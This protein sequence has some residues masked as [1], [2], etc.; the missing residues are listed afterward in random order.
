[1]NNLNP[2]NVTLLVILAGIFF[3]VIGLGLFLVMAFLKFKEQ[4]AQLQNQVTEKVYEQFF[5]LTTKLNTDLK[6][7]R[8]ELQLGLSRSTQQL[9]QKL[10]NMSSEV[11]AKLEKNITQGFTYFEKVQ[12]S[13][14]QAEKQLSQLNLVGDSVQ[15]LKQ[16]LSLPHLRGKLLGEA[17]LE[18]VLA[19]F[20]PAGYFALQYQI[21][22]NLVDAVVI[23]KHLNLVLPIDSK[24]SMEQI[25]PLFDQASSP[26]NLKIARKKL[27][28]VTRTNA[29]DIRAKYIKTKLGTTDFALMYL[30]SETLYFEVI[31]DT[32]LWS[33]ITE[34]KIYPVSP[35]TLAIT[36][37][38]I[39]KSVQYYEMA[40]DVQKTLAQLATARDHLEKFKTRFDDI[41]EKLFKAQD[42]FNKASTHYERYTSS[43]QKLDIK[44]EA[45]PPS[46]AI[47]FS[48]PPEV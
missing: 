13:L 48:A 14:V 24:F 40:K 34:Q 7:N 36:V 32:E 30:P 35:N 21:D 26:E 42:S 25:A 17:S 43:L 19:D 3:T 8:E 15:E 29:K 38:T 31:R 41:G 39:S 37:N 6:N 11:G 27:S 23:F 12:N 16:V 4:N 1:M 28:E 45:V 2:N 47:A 20:L 22:S 46:P 44:L 5:N 10:S 18:R 9:E 33:Q